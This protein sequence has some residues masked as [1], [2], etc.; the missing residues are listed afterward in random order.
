M[1]K[2]PAAATANE[3]GPA[4]AEAARFTPLRV[5]RIAVAGLLMG[6]A[7]LIPGVSGGTMILA[8]G[9]YQEFIDSVADITRFKFSFRRIAFLA[10]IGVCAGGAIV[11]LAGAI[12]YLLFHHT[13]A[14]FALFIGL[15]LGGAPLL[16]RALRPVRADVVISTVIGFGLMIGVF[17][18]KG[19]SG[20]PHNT[21][22]DFVSGV[23]GSTTMILP[24]IS[25]S[26]MLL[27]LDQYERVIGAIND[28][29]EAAQ[30]RDVSALKA[31]LW[32]IIPVG[33]GAV[34][35]IV[36][37]SNLLKFLL[38]RCARPTIGVLLGI[39]LGSVMGLW[40]FAKQPSEKALER[41]SLAELHSFAE[42]WQIPGAAEAVAGVD[43][44]KLDPVDEHKFAGLLRQTIS[45]NW[46][47]RGRSPYSPD[48]IITAL[49]A[50]A[51]GFAV[52]F[53]LARRKPAT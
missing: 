26:Y 41:R 12:L 18:L 2:P 43:L 6:I 13:I 32:I 8:M 3:S 33:I 52:T 29:K 15:T 36:A 38:H 25:G 45:D 9:V 20:M 24:G 46:S 14:M 28:F 50:A 51:I 49:V 37:L 27:V 34:L 39:L 22:M 47:K 30:H 11:G 10:L 17:L 40:P 1:D 48:L 16:T 53:A 5:V 44:N 23:I 35:G 7:N 4:P 42:S 21:P 19:G 31:A